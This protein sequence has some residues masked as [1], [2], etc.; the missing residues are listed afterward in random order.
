MHYQL[1]RKKQGAVETQ[2]FSLAYQDRYADSGSFELLSITIMHSVPIQ[3][4]KAHIIL[5]PKCILLLYPSQHE[6]Y[7]E[8]TGISSPQRKCTDMASTSDFSAIRQEDLARFPRCD[9]FTAEVQAARNSFIRSKFPEAWQFKRYSDWVIKQSLI[10]FRSQPP[11]H[12]LTADE[13]RS[14]IGGTDFG[15]LG[16]VA[17]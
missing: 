17:Q 16:Q 10:A 11:P 3:I 9:K 14:T 15:D 6:T 4:G 1:F 5:R 2:H 7:L 13:Y 12:T 8:H